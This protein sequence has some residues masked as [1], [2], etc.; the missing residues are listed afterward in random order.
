MK[1]LKFAE[2]L[3]TLVL[4]GEKT[5]TWRL[6]DDKDLQVGDELLFVDKETGKEFAQ[7]IILSTKEKKLNE[8]ID[9]DF[10]G[11]EKFE[12]EEKMYE[13]YR[14]YYGDRVTPETVVK[15]IKFKLL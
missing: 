5:S 13:A 2:H 14:M 1:T 9:T 10:E 15:I 8:L 11:H 3:V 6:F 4:S 7:A 12:S